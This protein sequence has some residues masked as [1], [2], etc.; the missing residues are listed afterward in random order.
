MIISNQLSCMGALA[1]CISLIAVGHAGTPAQKQARRE[2][3]ADYQKMDQSLMRKDVEG[4]AAFEA[5]DYRSFYQS[6]ASLS[7]AQQIAQARQTSEAVKSVPKVKTK[8]ISLT[9]RGHD[10]IVISQSTVVLMIMKGSQ[11]VRAERVG[12]CRDYWSHNPTG[13]QIRQSVEKSAKGWVNG[14]R[15]S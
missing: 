14:K 7:R 9:W 2:I 12:V 13:W 5:P 6:G 8:I 3:E 15:V 10:A 11:L 1:L 4:A